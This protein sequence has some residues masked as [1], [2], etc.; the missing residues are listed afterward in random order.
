[1]EKMCL[2]KN[3]LKRKS[4]KLRK[5]MVKGR[6]IGSGKSGKKKKI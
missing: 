6:R 4:C 2:I 5:S 1:M 3:K